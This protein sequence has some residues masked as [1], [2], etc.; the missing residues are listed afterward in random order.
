M[1]KFAGT[2]LI[3]IVLL[4]CS[5]DSDSSSP[6]G[7][8]LVSPSTRTVMVDTLSV[9]LS[10]LAGDSVITSGKGVM[11]VGEYKDAWIG[12]SQARSFVEFSRTTTV[13]T[14]NY[15]RFDSVTLVLC[16]NGIYYGDTTLRYQSV[17]ISELIQPIKMDD[18]GRR[19]STS[20][21]PVGNLLLN[22]K[23]KIKGPSQKEVEIRLP[24]NFGERLFSGIIKDEDEWKGEEYL[25]T[26]PGFAIE[27]GVGDNSCIYGFSVTD[28]T[29]MIRIYY[30]VTGTV[31]TEYGI[32][33][34]AQK[35]MEFKANNSTQFNQY[36]ITLDNSVAGIDKLPVN[37]KSDAVST[38]QTAHKGII[39]R[40][41][42]PLYTRIDFP[43]LNRLLDYGEI[44]LIERARLIIRPVRHSYDDNVPLPEE[45]R[46]FEHN[47]SNDSRGSY[48]YL[49]MQASTGAVALTGNLNG[50][51]KDKNVHELCYYDFDI[52]NFITSQLGATVYDQLSLSVDFP[53]P[54]GNPSSAYVAYSKSNT[55]FQRLIFG[56]QDFF[57]KSEE[58]SKDNQ[59]MLELVYSIYHEY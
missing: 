6:M 8:Y 41:P 57:Y 20:S 3:F 52:T 43:S 31:S 51:G 48:N 19:Y 32:V 38:G 33:G 55:P 39:L 22:G 27:R 17:K 45:L 14:D 42:L 35:T 18:D 16:P 36:D 40:G 30:R 23:Y 11:F 37:S 59:I 2:G 46:L 54:P 25:K 7:G 34:V 28:S 5:C 15:P 44:V 58:Q 1:D 50:T 47:P 49:T 26:F 12:T 4:F 56:D 29:C 21:E 24:D 9:K 13:E 10:V 53:D